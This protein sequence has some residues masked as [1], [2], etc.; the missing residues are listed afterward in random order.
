[1]G[2]YKKDCG[3]EACTRSWWRGPSSVTPAALGSWFSQKS[4]VS[5]LE[6]LAAGGWPVHWNWQQFTPGKERKVSEVTSESTEMMGKK[7][8]QT[9]C[10]QNSGN[11]LQR[12]CWRLI[13]AIY[14]P[15][16]SPWSSTE[17]SLEAASALDLSCG[18][19]GV[20]FVMLPYPS[21]SEW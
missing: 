1:M 11:F 9:S 7:I 6:R 18:F 10:R 13:P 19:L 14:C 12:R 4:A 2:I 21:L 8:E 15:A 20:V 17:D 5:S 3:T 16:R